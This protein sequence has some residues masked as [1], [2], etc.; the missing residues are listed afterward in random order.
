MSYRYPTSPILQD[1]AEKLVQLNNKELFK[2]SVVPSAI[3]F[4]EDT[5]TGAPKESTGR[6]RR[7]QTSTPKPAKSK[8]PFDIKV[9]HPALTE[10][11]EVDYMV[12]WFKLRSVYMDVNKLRAYLLETLMR[13]KPGGGLN[14]PDL[15]TFK[16]FVKGV[17]VDYEDRQYIELDVLESQLIKGITQ[18]RQLEF[19]G[20]KPAPAPSPEKATDMPQVQ[21][22]GTPPA[23]PVCA[24]EPAPDAVSGQV[25]NA[26]PPEPDWEPAEP[27]A[28]PV[29]KEEVSFK[30]GSE[31]RVAAAAD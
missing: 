31:A 21:P 4:V 13:I 5:I 24:S 29:Q 20:D 18:Q 22:D 3:L 17:G 30:P 6:R 19:G 9:L 1:W 23:E 27:Y 26:T 28:K 7:K 14:P 25:D 10:R 12:I 2:G 16:A 8:K 11:L 15:K